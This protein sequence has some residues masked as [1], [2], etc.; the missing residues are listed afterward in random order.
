MEKIN[1][2]W[3]NHK[4]IVIG[5]LAIAL[6]VVLGLNAYM[7]Y[8][9][10]QIET[11]SYIEL[12]KMIEDSQVERL[13]YSPNKENMK[14]ILTDGSELRTTYPNNEELGQVIAI[15]K[16]TFEGHFLERNFRRVAFFDKRL[17]KG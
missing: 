2:L 5:L 12:N 16:I 15:F 8:E 17:D 1:D 7:R 6:L 4:K 3:S 10:S 9:E 11:V 13:E 14:V